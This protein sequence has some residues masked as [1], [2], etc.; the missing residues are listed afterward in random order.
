MN[1]FTKKEFAIILN[2]STKELAVYA[3]PARK[4]VEYYKDVEGK[5]WVDADADKNK[6]FIALK[7]A[8]DG[9]TTPGDLRSLLPAA[10]PTT[11]KPKVAKVVKARKEKPKAASAIT[12]KEDLI[13]D[14]GSFDDEDEN[15]PNVALPA[16]LIDDAG[17]LTLTDS[18]RKKKH[19]DAYLAELNSEIAQLKRDKMAGMVLP[20]VMVKPILKKHNQSFLTNFDNGCQDIVAKFAKMADMTNEELAEM[21]GFLT[22]TLNNCID[23]ALTMSEK[24]VDMA[25][26]EFIE[27]K[28]M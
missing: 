4:K 1:L 19:H 8:K 5:E 11:P 18:E 12:R 23:K 13:V 6:A 7:R 26:D 15:I 27:T 20:S 21:K 28:K 24:L 14:A 16:A 25:I 22:E 2:C 10:E 3:S 9:L 17:W